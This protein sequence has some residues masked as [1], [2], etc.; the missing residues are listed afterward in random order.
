MALDLSAYEL[1]DDEPS[2][3]TKQNAM[4][5]AIENAANNMGSAS[6]GAFASGLI[7]D[8]AKIKQNGATNGQVPMWSGTAWVPTT[9]AGSEYTLIS[10]SLLVGDGT[11][12]FTGIA[13]SY[14]HLELVCYLRTDRAATQDDLGV[15]F[16]N[17]TTAN[18]D[19]YAFQMNGTAPTTAGSETLAGTSITIS[20]GCVGSS[21]TAN[22]FGTAIIRI[23]HYAGTSNN[24]AASLQL[25]KKIGVAAGNLHVISGLGA[26]RSSSAITRVDLLPLVGTNFKTGSRVTLYG[27]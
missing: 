25:S 15:R 8:L 21:A 12:S 5:Q 19:G 10:D 3:A 6:Y 1:G 22:V 20:N 16:N 11:F 17:D 13:G 2:S 23:P 18:Y 9:V 24:K 7:F 14:K 4:I 27:L 26:W